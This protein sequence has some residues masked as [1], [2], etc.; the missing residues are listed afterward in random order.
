MGSRCTAG[1][2][3]HNAEAISGPPRVAEC[4][5]G[6]ALVRLMLVVSFSSSALSCLVSGQVWSKSGQLWSMPGQVRSIPGQCWSNL[7]DVGPMLVNF[8]SKVAKLWAKL[9]SSGPML[10]NSGQILVEVG[11]FRAKFRRSRGGFGRNSSKSARTGSRS[12]RI[13]PIPGQT[14]RCLS[15]LSL[16]AVRLATRIW[17]NRGDFDRAWP[18]AGKYRPALGEVAQTSLWNTQC[19]F[20]WGLRRAAAAAGVGARGGPAWVAVRNHPRV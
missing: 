6:L 20:G 2:W 7:V 1:T 17:P 4:K 13:R 5:P 19:L 10:A 11:R 15:K 16:A 14:G 12:A 18:D 3:K 8:G 9:V